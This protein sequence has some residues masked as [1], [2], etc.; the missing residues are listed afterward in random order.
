M[1]LGERSQLSK[2][3]RS[4]RVTVNT[5]RHD[6][7][8]DSRQSIVQSI[9]VVIGHMLT[10][11][12]RPVLLPCNSYLQCLTLDGVPPGPLAHRVR[13]VRS[14]ALSEFQRHNQCPQTCVY[15]IEG[16]GCRSWLG[17]TDLPDLLA[18]MLERGYSIQPQLTKI[19]TSQLPDVIGSFEYR[20]RYYR[21]LE[22]DGYPQEKNE[23]IERG[24]GNAAS[25]RGPAL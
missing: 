23:T 16:H 17:P 5:S 12:S 25:S 3:I 11:Y 2:N 19:L 13:Q 7:Y 6:E 21:P 24:G 18:W 8:A 4:D 14:L 20:D 22:Q 9:F 1:E 10:I 15:L